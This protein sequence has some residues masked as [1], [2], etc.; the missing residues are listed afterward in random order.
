MAKVEAVDL[1]TV[2]PRIEIFFPAETQRRI[3]RESCA[4]KC[5][6]SGTKKFERRLITDFDTAA[7]DQSGAAFKGCG[8]ESFLIIKISALDAHGIV[9]EMD[10]CV[11]RFTDVAMPG[12]LEI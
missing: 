9:K 11:V 2:L 1:Q 3:L 5:P 8:L 4:D 6:R 10:A 7:G 12:I